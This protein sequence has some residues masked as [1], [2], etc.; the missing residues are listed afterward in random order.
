MAEESKISEDNINLQLGDIV[1]INFIDET[2]SVFMIEY[3]DENKIT[4]HNDDKMYDVTINSDKSLSDQT[5]SSIELLSR[6]KSPSYAVLNNLIPP[7]WIN[8]HFGGDVLTILTGQIIG[9]DEDQIEIKLLDDTIIYI[10]FAYKG[11]PLDIPI[12]KIIV[13]T[14]PEKVKSDEL[15]IKEESAL[16]EDED[17]ED[18]DDIYSPKVLL[19]R[20]SKSDKGFIITDEIIEADNIQFGDVLDEVKQVVQVSEKEKRYSIEK[21]AT[22]ML[23]ELLSEIPNAE[24]SHKV[25]NNLHKMIERFKQLRNK[26]ST[27][28]ERGNASKPTLK[29]ANHKPLVSSL[30]N[31][32]QN[33]YWILPVVKHIKKAYTILN[34]TIGITQSENEDLAISYIIDNLS[35]FSEIQKIYKSG[36]IPDGSTPYEY[37]LKHI[38]ELTTPYEV[39]KK[40]KDDSIIKNILVNDNIYAVHNIL[41]NYY[42]TSLLKYDKKMLKEVPFKQRFVIQKYNLGLKNTKSDEISLQ[43]FIT[44]PYSTMLFSK[45]SLPSTSIMKRAE[46][47]RHFLNYWKFLKRNTKVNRININKTDKLM[48]DHDTYLQ[49]ITD[50]VPNSDELEYSTYLDKFVPKTRVFFNLIKKNITGTLT[51]NEVINHL[52]PFMVYQ[53][54]MSFKQYQEITEFL[55]E[56]INEYKKNYALKKREYDRV[57]IKKMEYILNT[58]FNV[59]K[60]EGYIT[61]VDE[62]KDAYHVSNHNENQMDFLQHINNI[63]NGRFYNDYISFLSKNLK[64]AEKIN[65]VQ[66]KEA[67]SKEYISTYAE[68]EQKVCEKYIIAKEYQTIEDLLNDNGIDITFDKKYDKT[69]YD[70]AKDYHSEL[71]EIDSDTEKVK[72]LMRELVRNVGLNSRQA[73]IDATSIILGKRF[74]QPNEYAVLNDNGKKI[75]FVRTEDKTWEEAIDLNQGDTENMFCNIQDGCIVIDKVKGCGTEDKTKMDIEKDTLIEIAREYDVL[76]KFFDENL[77][78]SRKRLTTLY[79]IYNYNA[80]KY[81]IY[82]NNLAKEAEEISTIKSPHSK[83]LSLI[84]GQGDFVKKQIDISKFVTNFTRA[85]NIDDGE[86]KWWLYCIDTNTKLL[87][88]FVSVLSNTFIN[89]ENYFVQM[90]KI[91]ADQGELSGDG[92]AIIDK[93]SGWIITKIDFSTDEGFTGEGFLEK[94]R[95]LMTQDV[96]DMIVHEPIESKFED[97]TKDS[98][99]V[100]MIKSIINVISAYAG[101]NLIDQTGFI[102]EQTEKLLSKRMPSKDDY[103]KALEAA[104]RK[105]KKRLDSYETVYGQSI[106]FMTL[107]FML[108]AIQTSIPPIKTKKTFVGCYKSFSG[109][110]SFNADDK[111]GITYIACIADKIKSKTVKPWDSIVKLNEKKL[112]TKMQSI[113]DKFILTDDYIKQLIIKKNKYI[114]THDIDDIP[115]EHDIKNWI[116]FLPPLKNI[117]PKKSEAV[118]KEYIDELTKSIQIGTIT[119]DEILNA[120]RSKQI[121]ITTKIID[122][123][124]KIIHDN[125]IKQGTI[126]ESGTLEPFLENACCNDESK[127]NTLDYFSKRNENIIRKIRQSKEIEKLTN[128]IKILEKARILFDFSD[129]TIKYPKLSNE[130]SEKTIYKAF[131]TYCKYNQ[132]ISLDEELKMVCISKPKSYSKNNTLEENINILKREGAIYN[133]DSLSSLM[134]IIN[135]RN[136]VDIKYKNIIYKNSQKIKELLLSMTMENNPI[137]PEFIELMTSLID[138]DGDKKIQRDLKNY[139]GISITEIEQNIIKQLSKHVNPKLSVKLKSCI[140]SLLK[141][142]NEQFTINFYK[143]SIFGLTKIIPYMI[144]HKGTLDFD[145]T[146][147]PKH[148]KLSSGHI[149]DVKTFIISYYSVFNQ[150]IKSKVLSKILNVFVKKSVDILYLSEYLFENKNFDNITVSLLLQFYLFTLINEIITISQNPDLIKSSIKDRPPNPLVVEGIDEVD[151]ISTGEAAEPTLERIEGNQKRFIVEALMFVYEFIQFTCKNKKIIDYDYDSLMDKITLSKEIEKD[152][153]V[154]FLTELTDEER[155]IENKFKGHKLEKWSVGMQKGFRIYQKGMYDTELKEIRGDLETIPEGG[156][157]RNDNIYRMDE[158]ERKIREELIYREEYDISHIGEDGEDMEEYEDEL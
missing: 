124:E 145:N 109:Y 69:F 54:D 149:K 122:Y 114:E 73:K 104:K 23:N 64:Q 29:G 136:K 151:I 77:E 1:N 22:D 158:E 56:K 156:D 146:E 86:D 78:I 39:I 134:D 85:A 42:S 50:Y 5:I 37:I 27:F 126:L 130:F 127:I 57:Y 154:K 139:I 51:L 35:E 43:S 72:F 58:Y 143:N 8:I 144:L 13:R 17:E 48:F 9:I 108:I 84:L 44:L 131:I 66:D 97:E 112:I 74:V 68:E 14:K 28:D 113:I 88:T 87:P 106:I 10:D 121:Y 70:I 155:E 117:K 157:D 6:G 19:S 81:N 135:N 91:A 7:N 132:N 102:I 138:S 75:F 34:G 152:K 79:K 125:V 15:L 83:L 3:I 67:W 4:F 110:P 96:G 2:S 52:E 76:D 105:G 137:K 140:D 80:E 18:D 92:D 133:I 24:R 123:I 41:K 40:D 33:L 38:K 45:I 100:K 129:T 65:V 55:I 21:Q 147:I 12:E 62:I 89:K 63:D 101:I 46:L 150:F 61:Q 11:I 36:N 116:N 32:N 111:S 16:E 59:L 107:S 49:N 99:E 60:G 26:F 115:D 31:L 93:Y 153:I 141:F 30:E 94:T 103:E 71:K 20:T 53:D 47:N 148:W 90:Q 128:S 95:D 98:K 118:T 119:Q 25:L 142:N 82:K 120:L